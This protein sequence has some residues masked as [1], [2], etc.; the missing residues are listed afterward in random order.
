MYILIS[1]IVF[2]LGAWTVRWYGIIIGIGALLGLILAIREGKRF[3]VHMDFFKDLVLIGLPSA[4]VGARIYFV[5][6]QW[7]SYKNTPP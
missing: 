7:D 2:S 1:P 3:G 5:A 4:L 6:F